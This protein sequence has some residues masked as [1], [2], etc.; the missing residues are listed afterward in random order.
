MAVATKA[1]FWHLCATVDQ[2]PGGS[3]T[4]RIKDR[5]DQRPV[6]EV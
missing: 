1:L 2:R 4:G 3:K 5:V 6:A